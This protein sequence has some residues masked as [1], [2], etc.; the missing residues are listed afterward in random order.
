M[1]LVQRNEDMCA[2]S[3]VLIVLMS[4]VLVAV[5]SGA[6]QNNACMWCV[7]VCVCACVRV[8]V[9]ACVRVC[10]CACVRVCVCACV[11]VCVCA[12]VRVCV[13]ACVCMCVTI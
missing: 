12:C 7:R 13:C 11:R 6:S 1:T 5:H 8:C 4:V 2:E 10:V 9:C 3:M